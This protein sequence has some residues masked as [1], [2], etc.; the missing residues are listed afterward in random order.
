M[1]RCV[2]HSNGVDYWKEVM[3]DSKSNFFAI[4]FFLK[5]SIVFW[6]VFLETYKIHTEY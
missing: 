6:M 2:G 5:F 3:E 4:F 1:G